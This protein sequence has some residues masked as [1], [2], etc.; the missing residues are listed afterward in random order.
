MSSPIVI[1]VA[2]L[3]T[4]YTGRSDQSRLGESPKRPAA[5]RLSSSRTP[6]AVLALESLAQNQAGI[7]MTA[8]SQAETKDC[9]QSRSRFR[10]SLLRCVNTLHSKS[11]SEP[12]WSEFNGYGDLGSVKATYCILYPPLYLTQRPEERIPTLFNASSRDIIHRNTL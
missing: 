2:T 8:S 11:Y 6:S 12:S 4:V 9:I 10:E 5:S 7:R 1:L 3:A